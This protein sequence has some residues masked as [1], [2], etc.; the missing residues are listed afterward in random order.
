[1]N[2]DFTKHEREP[3][4]IVFALTLDKKRFTQRIVV[5]S[6]SEVHRRLER[7][8]GKVYF[9]E[10][11]PLGSLLLHME[12]DPERLWNMNAMKLN[13]SYGKGVLF[14]GER[15]RATEQASDFLRQKYGQE[16]P[17]AVFAAIRT[18][19]EYLG[20]YRQ[21]HGPE[22][23]IDRTSLLYKSF[24]L[25][26]QY[27]PWQEESGQVLSGA[28]QPRESQVELWYPMKKRPFECVV[29]HASLQPV[30]FYYLH[31]IHE[32]GYVFGECKVCGQYFLAR[33]RHYE[34]CSDSCRKVQAVEAKRQFDE[35]AKDDR[36]EQLHEAAYYYWYNRIRKLKRSGQ[37]ERL[38]EVEA[39]F[40]EFRAEAIKH[41]AAVKKNEMKLS[42]FSSWLMEQQRV[43]DRLME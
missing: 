33:S 40:A 22:L 27:R 29:A 37:T 24:F 2:Y 10:V 16:E 11:R 21:R 23:F 20:C 18:W 4:R 26:G 38:A 28:V 34:L 25:Y 36:L 12:A 13:E 35:R 3:A 32:W 15:W 31:K 1:M 8:E 6:E 17:A 19:E 43:I 14:E 7:G 30:I 5:G 9:D 41:K 39:T 42:D